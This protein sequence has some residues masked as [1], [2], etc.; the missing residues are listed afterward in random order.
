MLAEESEQ[1][2]PAQEIYINASS[3][4]NPKYKAAYNFATLNTF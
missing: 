1:G 4:S 3:V 2:L